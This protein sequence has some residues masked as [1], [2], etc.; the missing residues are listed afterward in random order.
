MGTLARKQTWSTSGTMFLNQTEN[1][2]KMTHGNDHFDGPPS[3]E[4]IISGV[5]EKNWYWRMHVK[6]RHN[7]LR[8]CSD[9]EDQVFSRITYAGDETCIMKQRLSSSQSS[10]VKFV[11]HR[12]RSSRYLNRPAKSWLPFLGTLSEFCSSIPITKVF[13]LQRNILEHLKESLEEKRRGKLAAVLLLHDNGPV[14]K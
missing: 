8:L 9:N 10:G 11:L 14:Y 13:L 7:F 3:I 5:I 1:H 4:V 6:R 12:E 2:L